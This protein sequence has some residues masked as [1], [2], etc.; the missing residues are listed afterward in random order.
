MSFEVMDELKTCIERVRTVQKKAPDNDRAPRVGDGVPMYSTSAKASN[1]TNPVFCPCEP[2]QCGDTYTDNNMTDGEDDND[3]DER[4]AEEKKALAELITQ[5]KDGTTSKEIG[6]PIIG[7]CVCGTCQFAFPLK[8]IA[9]RA[10]VN[11]HCSSCRRAHSS[12]FATYVAVVT[13]G[14]EYR[15]ANKIRARVDRCEGTNTEVNR[16]FCGTCY[17]T[18]AMLP[19]SGDVVFVTAGPLLDS[20]LPD[21]LKC[22][23]MVSWCIQA[24]PLYL[25]FVPDSKAKKAL[26]PVA[27]APISGGCACGGCRYELRSFPEELQHCYCK[28]CRRRSG[29]AWQTWMAIDD[30]DLTWVRKKGLK[31]LRST[32]HAKRHVCKK[33]GV[34]LTLVHDADGSIW[35]CAGTLDDGSYDLASM[36]ERVTAVEH[37]C[38]K[39]KQPWW[40][41]PK[42]GLPQIQ[43]SS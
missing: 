33:C 37:I 39:W 42:D 38:V 19:S 5:F 1:R 31:L 43:E 40:E 23:E 32:S 22:P 12:A 35:P 4:D 16:F 25:D 30:G 3:G 27:K 41:I 10:M 36:R 15:G 14:V 2:L 17:S 21:V 9:S 8:K 34:F 20:T 7:R 6:E 13:V 29:A 24:A 28:E 26:Q 18:L 11:C